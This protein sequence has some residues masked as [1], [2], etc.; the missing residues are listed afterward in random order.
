VIYFHLPCFISNFFTPTIVL[1]IYTKSA[2]KGTTHAWASDT[3]SIAAISNLPVQV[4]EHMHSRQFRAKSQGHTLHT[5]RFALLPSAQFL[6]TLCHSP[7]TTNDS[8]M[9][10]LT[11]EDHDIFKALNNRRADIKKVII[12][13][14]GKKK[15]GE[16]DAGMDTDDEDQ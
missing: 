11:Q 1:S 4:F 2:G 15:K 3:S 5:R 13:L 6:C 14:V 7:S 9:F 12:V 10:I 8:S 16:E